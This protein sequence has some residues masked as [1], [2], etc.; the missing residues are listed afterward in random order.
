MIPPHNPFLGRT[1]LDL[2]GVRAELERER[3][4]LGNAPS[5]TDTWQREVQNIDAQLTQVCAAISLAG[6]SVVQDA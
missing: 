3:E 1:I 6:S 5:R 4:V 2:E